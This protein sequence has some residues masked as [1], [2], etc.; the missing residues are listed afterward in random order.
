MKETHSF[1]Q[2]IKQFVLLFFPIFVTQMSLFAMS[3][4]DTTMSGHASATDLAG[5]AIGTSIWIPVSTGLTGILIATTPIIAQLVGSKQKDQVPHIVIQAVYLAIGVSLLVILIG[6]FAVSPILN[7]MHLD[8]QVEHIAAQFLSIIAIG[9]IPLFVYTVLRSFIDALGKTRTTMIITLLSL[10]INVI[11]NYVFIFGNFGFP[12]LGGVGA[13]IASTATYWCIL[14][15]T[16]I[17]IRT[18]EPFAS[19]NIFRHLY[20]LSMSSWKELL[21]LG[22]PIGF[23]IFFE[24]SIFAAVTLMM[25]NF[26]TTTIAAHQAAMNFASLLYM[27]PLSLAMAM[28]IAV[29]FEVGANRYTNAKQYSFIGIGLALAFSL[30]YSILLFV[31]DDQIAS[32]YTTDIAVHDLAK[33]FL[34]FAILFQISDAIATPVQGALRGYKD[35]NM[36]L[37]MTLIAY[38]IIGLP[39]GYILATYTSWAAK[40]YWIGLIIGLAFGA[41]FLLIRLFQVQRKYTSQESH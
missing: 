25:S 19:F 35:V 36:A 5:V 18:K 2:K 11:L 13:A 26:N 38:W 7:G 17:I 3:F 34:I 21:K 24:T 10:P 23:A 9:I 4:F 28:T 32:I 41:T 22:V 37:I 8:E 6:F 40:G 39:L 16:I 15:I 1:L 12:K 33:E 27:T 30:L 20:R 31:F 14:L 29:G